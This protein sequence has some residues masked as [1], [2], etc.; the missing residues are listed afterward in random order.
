MTCVILYVN[1][2]L[3]DR[4]RTDG[5]DMIYVV[6]GLH[7]VRGTERKERSA[8]TN[9]YWSEQLKLHTQHGSGLSEQCY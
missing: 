8:Q 2:L 6:T 3:N 5:K 7:A 1:E 4:S 9:V